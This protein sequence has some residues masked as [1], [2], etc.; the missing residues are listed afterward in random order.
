MHA[1]TGYGGGGIVKVNSMLN[2][3]HR[4]PSRKAASSYFRNLVVSVYFSN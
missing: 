3:S 1:I 2:T 4:L